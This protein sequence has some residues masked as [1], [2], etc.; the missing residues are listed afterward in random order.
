M[1]KTKNY[2]MP[3]NHIREVKASGYVDQDYISKLSKED[4]DWMSQFLGEYYGLNNI[5]T[6]EAI[7]STKEL[8]HKAYNTNRSIRRDIANN[9]YKVT[10]RITEEDEID[11]SSLFEE[12]E[13]YSEDA[14][15]ELMDKRLGFKEL[16]KR[17]YTKKVK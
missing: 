2:T 4:K 8:K 13:V 12:S 10:P 17:K 6:E 3:I 5:L 16:G 11:E 1:K 9:G 14:F 7:H 15:V